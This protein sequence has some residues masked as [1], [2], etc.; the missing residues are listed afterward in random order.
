MMVPI[1]LSFRILRWLLWIAFLA[2]CFYVRVNRASIL[3]SLNQLPQ[4]VEL[5][6]Y[7]LAVAAVFMGFLELQMREKA[8]LARP[9]FGRMATRIKSAN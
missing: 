5:I 9:A 8:G 1:W 6:L 2:Y 3:T 4:S 7:S